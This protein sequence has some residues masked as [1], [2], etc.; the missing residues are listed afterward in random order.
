MPKVYGSIRK[1]EN[2]NS[3]RAPELT[4]YVRLGGYKGQRAEEKN[5]ECASW[6]RNLAKDFAENKQTYINLAVWKAEDRESGEPYFSICMEDSAWRS[7]N[8]GQGA[9]GQSQRSVPNSAS[10]KS[11]DHSELEDVD[12]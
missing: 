9:G 4:G 10:P 6:L 5:R 3:D 7:S 2:R 11:A 12:F 8:S 1:N